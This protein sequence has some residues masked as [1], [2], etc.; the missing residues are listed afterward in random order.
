MKFRNFGTMLEVSRNM[1]MTVDAVKK[2]IDLSKEMGH[3]LVLLYMED[4]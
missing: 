2:W 3:N 1:I 4:G